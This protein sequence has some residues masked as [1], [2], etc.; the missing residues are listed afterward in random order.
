MAIVGYGNIGRGIAR[1]AMAFGIVACGVRRGARTVAYADEP[2]GV[3]VRSVAELD[4]VLAEA[5]WVVV[6]VPGTP[7]TLG[8]IGP[9][10]FA[11]MKPGAHLVHVARG[12]V[13]DEDAL[14]AALD[15]GRLAGA[16]LDV[17]A[18]EPLPPESRLWD[19]PRV[20][21]TP[22]VSGLASDYATQVQRLF[23]DN[24]RRFLEGRALRNVIDRRL[25]Y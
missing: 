19:H 6:V 10:Q 18:A 8:L 25:G 16:A 12:G 1:A 23:S 21:V 22:H 3:R 15:G 7:E 5:D 17:F 13:V 14:L 24:L 2:P 11:A 20:L 9:A 4:A